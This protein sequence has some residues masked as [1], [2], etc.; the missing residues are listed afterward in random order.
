[1]LCE[2]SIFAKDI[3]KY[4]PFAKDRREKMDKNY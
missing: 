2:L 3:L 4:L 1:M